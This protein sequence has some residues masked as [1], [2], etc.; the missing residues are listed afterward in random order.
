MSEKKAGIGLHIITPFIVGAFCLG[1]TATLSTEPLNKLKVYKN[2]IF[3]DDLKTLPDDD[4]TGLVVVENEI[5]SDYEGDTSEKGE[6]QRPSFGELFAIL[7]CDALETEVPV[8]WGSGNELLELG[9]CQATNSAV[10]GTEGNAVISAH[11]DTFF[12]KLDKVGEGDRITVKT[13]YGE[14]IYT[15]KEKISFNSNDRSFVVPTEDTRLT[16]YTCYRDIL[17][18]SDKRFGVVCELS[19]S[20]F[21]SGEAEK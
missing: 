14:F 3:M 19:E 11:V 17:G 12:S 15:V 13:N 7:S 6:V 21:Y 2:L 8:Y 10:V 9:A 16:L 1:I 4:N 18:N 20:K 5:I